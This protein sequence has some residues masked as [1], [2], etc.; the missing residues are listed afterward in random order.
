ML[1][2]EFACP[3][4]GVDCAGDVERAIAV[5]WV[6]GLVDVAVVGVR[7]GEAAANATPPVMGICVYWNSSA[8]SVVVMSASAGEPPDS[9]A[10]ISPEAVQ[11]AETVPS[12]EHC[13]VAVL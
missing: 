2:V 6:D 8:R 12:T 11:T 10:G 7:V 3:E 5:C 1:P 13:T 4:D 9:S